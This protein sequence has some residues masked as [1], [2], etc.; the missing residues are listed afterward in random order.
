MQSDGHD[1]RRLLALAV[2][3]V[4]I[5]AQRDE[6]IL[7]LTPAQAKVLTGSIDEMIPLHEQAIRL[8][9]RDPFIS[10]QYIF[11]GQVH[12]LQSRG[13]EAIVPT[14]RGWNSRTP[15]SPAAYALEGDLARAAA[16][17]SEAR[18][19]SGRM[20]Y[21][22]INRIRRGKLGFRLSEKARQSLFGGISGAAF[23][24]AGI[25]DVARGFTAS[26]D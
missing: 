16:G 20:G 10:N 12:F 15:G 22:S 4:E 19:L 8:S 1:L 24:I 7:G 14:I 11:I 6:E 25:S 13:Q 23:D 5:V 26:R 9:P 17:F 18:K 21:S 3:R 2:E